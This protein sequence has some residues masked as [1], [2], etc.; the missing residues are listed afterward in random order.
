[1]SRFQAGPCQPAPL[2]K[3]GG[4]WALR[5]PDYWSFNGS[6]TPFLG[7]PLLQNI[8]INVNVTITANWHVYGGIGGGLAPIPGAQASVRGGWIN[9][10]K[11][12]P[13][14]P[15]IDNFVRGPSVT[16]EG[17]YPYL[18]VLPDVGVGPVAAET[19]G[20]PSL[21]HLP[22]RPFQDR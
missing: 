1:V 20:Y 14:G 13:S 11:K 16:A 17:F 6:V 22:P 8:Q 10:L 4:G 3:G 5:L 7:I 2:P 9:Q 15:Q 19:W 21:H 18:E 12:A